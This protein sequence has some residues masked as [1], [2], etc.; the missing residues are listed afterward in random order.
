MA[1][2]KTAGNSSPLFI[3]DKL[4]KFLNSVN[5]KDLSIAVDGNGEPLLQNPYT[6]YIYKKTL[7]C[8]GE[9]FRLIY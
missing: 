2:Q 1:L 8:L 6:F 7:Q 4:A 5:K 9:F 3:D